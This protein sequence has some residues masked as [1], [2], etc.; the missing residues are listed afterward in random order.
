MSREK[1]GEYIALYWD[2]TAPF[3]AVR[4]HVSAEAA[5]EE[6]AGEAGGFPS[7]YAGSH[8]EHRWAR[9][10]PAPPGCDWDLTFTLCQP[11]RG[12]FAV[13]LIHAA[14]SPA[15]AVP[16]VLATTDTPE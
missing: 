7:D 4:G 13:T 5:I 14:P 16:G 11:G 9:W 6:V 8:V 12:A 1:P 3:E 2:N 15:S 10:V